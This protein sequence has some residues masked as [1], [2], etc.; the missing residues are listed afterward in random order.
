MDTPLVCRKFVSLNI[1]LLSVNMSLRNVVII[2]ISCFITEVFRK[3][4][5]AVMPS[6]FGMFVL[7][8]LLFIY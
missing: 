2:G 3:D 8:L 4:M 7:L 6:R 1:K 5:T